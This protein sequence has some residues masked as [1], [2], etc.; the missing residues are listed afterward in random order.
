M[1]AVLV[2]LGLTAVV[3]SLVASRFMDEDGW[4]MEPFQCRTEMTSIVSKMTVEGDGD[5]DIGSTRKPSLSA[6]AI[7]VSFRLQSPR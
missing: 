2:S 7:M 1:T 5:G 3:P 4:I 6:R